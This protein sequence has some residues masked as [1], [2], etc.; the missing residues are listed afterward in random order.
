VGGIPPPKKGP[1]FSQK[2]VTRSAKYA[3]TQILGEL[4]RDASS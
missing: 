2:I 3:L 1:I 4:T